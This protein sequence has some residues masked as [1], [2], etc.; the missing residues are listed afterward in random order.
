ML[1][2]VRRV[3]ILQHLDG[4]VYIYWQA[5]F[6][7][8]CN[9]TSE[10]SI[11]PMTCL[12]WKL[13]LKSPAISVLECICGFRSSSITFMSPCLWQS[14][15]R[16]VI[17][18]WSFPLV[19]M[20]SLTPYLPGSITFPSPTRN[21]TAATLDLKSAVLTLLLFPAQPDIQVS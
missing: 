9:L 10:F 15:I 3:C 14:K 18:Y 6:D 4:T 1:G 5:P 16:L 13:V 7:L 2:L 21:S 19:N 12:W 20:E 11:F 17:S 8:W